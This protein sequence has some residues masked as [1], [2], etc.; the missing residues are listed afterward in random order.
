MTGKERIL[1]TLRFEEPDRPPHFEIMFQL[2]QEAFG[3]KF[4]D[5]GDWRDCQTRE[6]KDR[7]VSR[8]M[9]IYEKI[10]E[11]FQWDGLA[12]YFPWSDPDGVR[13]ATAPFGNNNINS[14]H[15]GAT[16]C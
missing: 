9:T 11:R 16:R 10:V 2:E 6:A 8:C 15:G 4:P 5:W 7:L 1:K 13:A 14:R 12:V 3:L